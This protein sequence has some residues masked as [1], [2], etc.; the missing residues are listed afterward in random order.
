MGVC[1]VDSDSQSQGGLVY[2]AEPS[3][4]DR[5][6][7]E[8][9]EV[10][11]G[12]GVGEAMTMTCLCFLPLELIMLNERVLGTEGSRA[13]RSDMLRELSGIASEPGGVFCW[14]YIAWKCDRRRQ[15]QKGMKEMKRKRG[16]KKAREGNGV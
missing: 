15:E 12:G 9:G 6:G 7:W 11:S 3:F 8:V 10:G 5:D 1:V 2:E 14:A 13:P 4:W 16:K